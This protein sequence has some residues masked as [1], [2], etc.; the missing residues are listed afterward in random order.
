[1]RGTSGTASRPLWLEALSSELE[2]EMR[3]GSEGLLEDLGDE[4]A[5]LARDFGIAAVTDVN[6]TLS[7][8]LRIKK[9]GAQPKAFSAQSPGERLRLRIAT[10]VAL[11]RV[12]ARRGIATHPGLLM[13]DSLRAEEV[14]ESDAHAVLDALLEIAAN[15]PGLQIITTTADESLPDGRLPA[16]HVLRPGVA[17]GALW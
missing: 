3:L 1:M 8:A 12:G 7:A 17:G 6:V 16:D 10:V 2:S 5:T 9:G 4:I 15:T 11:L 13:I 14:Q